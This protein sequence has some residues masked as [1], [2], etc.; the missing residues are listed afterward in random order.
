LFTSKGSTIWINDALFTTETLFEMTFLRLNYYQG[1]LQIKILYTLSTQ[2]YGG[3]LNFSNSQKQLKNV[4]S[5]V[6]THNKI[7]FAEKFSGFQEF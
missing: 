7:S 4:L 6:R 1:S 5:R 2:I 3:F